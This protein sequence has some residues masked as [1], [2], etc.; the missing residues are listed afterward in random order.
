MEEELTHDEH[1][2]QVYSSYEKTL[3]CPAVHIFFKLRKSRS[4]S[5]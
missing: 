2:I 4:H 3:Y 1:I 5:P